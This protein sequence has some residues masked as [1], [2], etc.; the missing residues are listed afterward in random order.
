MIWHYLL[1]SRI[2][3]YTNPSNT[4]Y[5][6]LSSYFAEFFRKTGLLILAFKCEIYGRVFS[7]S[8]VHYRIAMINCFKSF[9]EIQE[10]QV[11][12]PFLIKYSFLFIY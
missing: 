5:N 8:W 9:R 4:L 12:L 11:F 1:G 2:A 6:S 10:Y 7:R 3:E